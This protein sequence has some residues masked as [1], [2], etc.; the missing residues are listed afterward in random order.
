MTPAS[1]ATSPRT[2]TP[3]TPRTTT[4][5]DQVPSVLT[6]TPLA[7]D[8]QFKPVQEIKEEDPMESYLAENSS[9]SYDH[10]GVNLM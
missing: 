3:K 9:R 6:T 2:P 4:P 5:L 10:S 8:V 1:T 7:A